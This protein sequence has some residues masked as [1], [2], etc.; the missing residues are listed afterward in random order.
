M[1]KV[2]VTGGAGFIGSHIVRALAERDLKVHVVDNLITGRRERVDPR[3]TFH[4]ADIRN[5]DALAPIFAG[6]ACVFHAAAL[7][8]VQPSIADPRLTNDINAAGTVNVL[9]AARDAGVRRV[10]YS[11]SSSAYGNQN[12]LPLEEEMEP[13]PMSPYALQKYT[14]ELWCR[15]FSQ[16]FGTGTVSLRYFNVYGPGA[17]TQGAYALVIGRF[18]EQRQRGEPLTIVP[19]GNQSRDFTHV[20]DVVRANLLAAESPKVGAGEVI[21]IGG[22]R[23]KSVNEVAALIGGPTVFIEPRVEPK[24]TRADIRR[25]K[26]LLRWEPEVPFEEGVT[27]LK[28]MHGLA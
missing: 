4:E 12:A 15:L 8:R 23:N 10:V 2:V 17:S 18:L 16:L 20:R 13:R 14:G 5:F 3:A 27:E 6:A 9:V 24:H 21:N 19:D 26:E 25:A 1:S 7:P 22:G 11:A 28:A